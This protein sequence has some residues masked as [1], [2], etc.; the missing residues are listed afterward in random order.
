MASGEVKI[1]ESTATDMDDEE[2]TPLPTS[3]IN[4]RKSQERRQKRGSTTQSLDSFTSEGSVGDDPSKVVQVGN[5]RFLNDDDMPNEQSSILG[6]GSFAMVRLARRRKCQRKSSVTSALTDCSHR[7]GDGG[8]EQSNVKEKIEPDLSKDTGDGPLVAVKI[9]EKSLL[10]KCRTIERD[11]DNQM[12]VRTALE[13]VEREIAV[14]KIIQHPNLVLL[15]E[16]ID[17][18]ANRLYMVLEYHPLGEIMT[19]VVGTGKYRRRPMR[20]GERKLSGITQDGHFDEHHAAL[21]FVDIMHGLAHLHTNH[22]VHRDLKPENI[23]LDSRGVAKI[24]DFGVAHLF[25]DEMKSPGRSSTEGTWC[26][27]APEMCAENSLVFSG[28]ACDIWAAGVCLFTFATGRLPFYS[29]IPLVL[30]D[31]IAAADV[32]YDDVELSDDLTDLLKKVLEKNP[33]D[34]VGVGDCLQHKYCKEARQQRLRELGEAVE[35]HEEVVVQ[36][37]DLQQA[38][39]WTKQSSVMN[40]TRT[41]GRQFSWV[42][43]RFSGRSSSR[44]SQNSDESQNRQSFD[45]VTGRRKRVSVDSLAFWKTQKTMSTDEGDD[46]GTGPNVRRQRLSSN[47]WWSIRSN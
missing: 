2:P 22:I 35:E 41:M 31:A 36:S 30:F 40:I 27:W 14:M 7:S 47:L 12:Q 4:R 37:E 33:V 29:E 21:Y 25:E 18:G 46:E 11:S 38:F 3:E 32:K 45:E 20:K 42:K 19:N 26:Y 23:L 16:V 15:Y 28:Y 17:P 9:F 34:R 8:G 44:D 6:R 39:S 24:S 5:L 10:E 13:N 1:A 43:S